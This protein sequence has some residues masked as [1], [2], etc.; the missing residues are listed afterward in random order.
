M[1]PIRNSAVQKGIAILLALVFWQAVAMIVGMDI[2]F[3]SPIRVIARLA[4]IWLEE[5]F[6]STILFSF[7][8]IVFGFMI[9]FVL[10]ALLAVLS[11]RFPILETLLWPYVITIKTVP[12]ASFIIISL[13]WLKSSQLSAFIS[14]LMVFPVIYSNVLSGMKNTDPKLLEMAHLYRVKWTRKLLYLYLPSVKPYL[15]SACSIALGMSWK[16]GIAAEVIGVVSG[17]IG[18]RLYESKIYF[19]TADLFC[20]TVIIVLVSVLFEKIFLYLL[21]RTFV[22]LERL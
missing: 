4:T 11:C 17:S 16:S 20:W 19:M 6:L 2:V 15:F 1:H 7:L 22:G 5:G 8:R 13:I 18:D 10:G 3:V 14:F 9:A 12:V 21:R